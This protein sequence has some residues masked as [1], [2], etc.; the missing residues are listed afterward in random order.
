MYAAPA[1]EAAPTVIFLHGNAEDIRHAKDMAQALT[2]EGLGFLALEYPG[3]GVLSKQSATEKSIYAATQAGID[4]LLSR[5]VARKQ[6]M[7]VG[8]SLGSGPAVEMAGRGHVARMVLI[9]P[10]TSIVDMARKMMPFAPAGLLV[11]D[12]FES[13]RKAPA[14]EIPVLVIHGRQDEIIPVAMGQR[15]AELL[16]QATLELLEGSGHNDLPLRQG[17]PL[18]EQIVAFL[19]D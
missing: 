16:P 12:R 3:Y 11:K 5:G 9:T 17:T 1:D 19:K 4:W 2:A 10:Y 6:I 14:I 13:D 7:I 8:R 15:M 18:M